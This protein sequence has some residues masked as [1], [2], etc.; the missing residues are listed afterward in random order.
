M[1]IARMVYYVKLCQNGNIKGNRMTESLK[2][3]Q[4]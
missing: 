1:Q 3:L 4:S 2:R